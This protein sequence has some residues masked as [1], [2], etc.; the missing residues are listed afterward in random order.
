MTLP[1]RGRAVGTYPG[2]D[3]DFLT[4]N[5]IATAIGPFQA[6]GNVLRTGGSNPFY[7]SGDFTLTSNT[8]DLT[9]T[10][11]GWYEIPEPFLGVILVGGTFEITGGT[12]RF[13]DAEGSGQAE[14]V[15]EFTE[16]GPVLRL[17]FRGT[18]T[19]NVPQGEGHG[20][21]CRRRGRRHRRGDDDDDEDED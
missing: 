19:M 2:G 21:R 4:V 12:E 10:Y 5:G 3:P 6:S 7:I 20:G 13:E 18:V 8:G 14:G 17:R 11:D 9:G 16:S 1:L 15:V